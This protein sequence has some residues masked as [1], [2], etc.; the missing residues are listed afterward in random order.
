MLSLLLA[1]SL[2][3]AQVPDSAHVVIVATTDVHGHT[4]GW[5]YV[6]H[7]PF[8]GG[9]ARVAPV[10]DSLR[11]RYPGQVV[12][13]D[14]GTCSGIYATYQAGWPGDRIRSS[15]TEPRGC[16]LATPN[17]HDRFRRSRLRRAVVTPPS[18]VSAN[19]FALRALPCVP[20][21]RIL[22]R[23]GGS[24]WPLPSTMVWNR[25]RCAARSG[26]T[27]GDPPR[28]RSPCGGFR[29][30]RRPA[31]RMG[32]GRHDTAGVGDDTWPPARRCPSGPTS[33]SSATPPGDGR[34]GRDSVHFVQPR[35]NAG[36][37]R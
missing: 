27:V 33:S 11:R 28:R 21:F 37:S 22:Q 34:L 35:R 2:A 18:L 17:S 8:P 7:R 14:A 29:P 25:D 19:L 24:A 6:A 13:L 10:V 12:V 1:A 5:D 3:V 30:H 4:T 16:D 20:P 15:S 26:S 31:Q 9:L 32:R 36:Q 23:Q